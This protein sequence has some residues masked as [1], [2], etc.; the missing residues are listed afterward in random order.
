MDL[1]VSRHSQVSSFNSLSATDKTESLQFVGAKKMQAGGKELGVNIVR[2]G[3]Q[4]FTVQGYVQC[5]CL[6]Y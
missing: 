4:N 6:Q 1:G 5:S 3:V 2:A